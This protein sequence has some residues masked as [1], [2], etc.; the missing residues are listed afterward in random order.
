MI[1]ARSRARNGALGQIQ[2]LYNSA[3]TWLQMTYQGVLANKGSNLTFTRADAT[4]CATHTDHEGVVRTVPAGCIRE[5]GAR[6]VRNIVP[7]AST[8]E[9]FSLAGWAKSGTCT[10][11]GTQQINL[12]AVN[13]LINTNATVPSIASAVIRVRC[14]M[15]GSGT[16]SIRASNN[17]NQAIAQQVTL[18][19]TPTWYTALFSFNSTAT[20]NFGL[21]PVCRLAGN[22]ATTVLLEATQYEIVNGQSNTNPSEYVSSGVLAAPYHGAGCDGIRYFNTTNGNTVV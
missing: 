18:S 1:R 5:T 12:P 21:N 20:T 4:V 16:I 13:D 7:A 8:S 10:V 19:S 9:N 22:T 15:S 17:I 6:M 11:T 3:A 2:R 14:L